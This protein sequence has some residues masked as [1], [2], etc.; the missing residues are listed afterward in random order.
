VCVTQFAFFIV[1]PIWMTICVSDGCMVSSESAVGT[2]V[3]FHWL[4]RC[5]WCLDPRCLL[6]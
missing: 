4:C 3:V 5:I 1:Y 6:L 2:V